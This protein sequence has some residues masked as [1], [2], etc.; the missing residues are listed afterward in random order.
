MIE[1][2]SNERVIKNKRKRNEKRYIGIGRVNENSWNNDERI[3]HNDR[4]Y[5]GRVV[6]EGY[7]YYEWN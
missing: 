3:I 4:Q 7:D 2:N 5:S 1:I 6:V